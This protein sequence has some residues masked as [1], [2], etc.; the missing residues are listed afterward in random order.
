MYAIGEIVLVVIGILIALS[1]N[2]WN[3]ERNDRNVEK[4]YLQRLIKDLKSDRKYFEKRAEESE[5]NIAN[6]KLSVAKMY[7]TQ[8]SLADIGDFLVLLDLSTNHLTIQ[9][10]TFTELTYSGNLILISNNDVK[11]SIINYYKQ[12]DIIAKHVKEANEWSTSRLNLHFSNHPIGYYYFSQ[13]RNFKGSEQSMLA[14]ANDPD[15]DAF[16]SYEQMVGAY[17]DKNNVFIK[18]FMSMNVR[19]NN[20]VKMIESQ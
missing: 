13:R 7:E 1:I 16:K 9:D 15:S 12:A 11:D 14:F 19:A 5:L 18:Y 2:N 17:Y 10:F 3:N 6:I 20:L 4:E 8:K